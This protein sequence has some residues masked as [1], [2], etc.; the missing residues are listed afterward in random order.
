VHRSFLLPAKNRLE[1]AHL[2]C[3]NDLGEL[4]LAQKALLHLLTFSTSF[5]NYAELTAK[6]H[7]TSNFA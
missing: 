7:L 2:R 1:S 5:I 3:P 4:S 6:K